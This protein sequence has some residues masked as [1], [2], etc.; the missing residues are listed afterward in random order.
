MPGKYFLKSFKLEAYVI[1]EVEEQASE[2]HVYCHTRARG[3]WFEGVYSEKVTEERVRKIPH[4][5]L[6]NKRVVL[7]VTQRRFAFKGTRRWEDLPDIEKYKQTSSTFRLHTLRELQ[8]D[9]YSGSGRK[10]HMSGMFPMKLLDGL[11]IPCEWRKGIKRVGL[12]GK[13]VRGKELVHHI[14]DLDEGKSIMILPGSGQAEFKKNF[15]NCPWKTAW[16][17]P[18]FV[19]TWMN[20][21]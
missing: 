21:T 15:W 7:V 4:M 2:I 17:L 13:Y 6:E 12:D 20:F 5:M 8:R 19:R 3:M 11:E 9:N 14:V 10:R 16:P 1:D 18:R